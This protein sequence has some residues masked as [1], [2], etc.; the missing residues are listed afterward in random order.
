MIFWA[1]PLEP[2]VIS[3]SR[4]PSKQAAKPN[5]QISAA[6]PVASDFFDLAHLALK[7]D[8]RCQLTL[9]N[10]VPIVHLARARGQNSRIAQSESNTKAACLRT[11][12]ANSRENMLKR[13]VLGDGRNQLISVVVDQPPAEKDTSSQPTMQ[14]ISMF[15]AIGLAVAT[16]AQFAAWPAQSYSPFYQSLFGAASSPVLSAPLNGG[17]APVAAA[18]PVFAAPAPVLA[19]PA[20]VFAAPAPVLAA[21]APV[22]AAPALP[23]AAPAVVRGPAYAYAPSPVLAP[24]RSPVVAPVA[25]AP[26]FAAPAPVLAAPAPVLAAPRFVPAYAPFARSA[27]FIGSNKAKMN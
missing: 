16:S 6:R 14:T 25:P 2:R 20:P 11:S 10:R 8:N 12:H 3:E 13:R 22:F 18:P 27:M 5:R 15:V 9:R 4:Q 7:K 19:A 1:V 23:V 26:V 21:P 17:V 24:L